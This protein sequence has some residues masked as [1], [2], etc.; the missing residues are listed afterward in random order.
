M[1]VPAVTDVAAT[2]NTAA[3]TATDATR[4]T[5]ATFGP[6]TEAS[7]VPS[8]AF[9]PF[10]D[11]SPEKDQDYFCE[12]LAEELIDALAQL[13]GVRVVARTSS[14]QFKGQNLVEGHAALARMRWCLD[15][16]FPDA[17]RDFRRALELNPA[18]VD[19]RS[20]YAGFLGFMGRT[21]EALEQVAR[22][23]ELDPLSAHASFLGGCALLIGRR[24]E[25][26]IAAFR[27][28]LDLDFDMAGC[29]A[30]L[31]M[32]YQACGQPEEAL[33]TAHKVAA[34]FPI[35][36]GALGHALALA[37]Q[38]SEA[39]RVLAELGEQAKHEY[40]G[41]LVFAY[42][43]LGLGELDAALDQLDQA[44]EERSP[45]LIYLQRPE[46]DSLRDHPRFQ[47]LRRRVGLPDPPASEQSSGS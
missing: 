45:G 29:L 41:P 32:S 20:S 2:L 34:R 33:A 27:Q 40:V 4:P 8:I 1:T 16:Q 44:Y 11:M 43:H 10:A 17:E 37:G 3:P 6:D 22:A 26:A 9:L 47:D 12:G 5:E 35:L 23:Q 46:W 24:Y 25:E 14:F 21:N 13:E 18:N 28:A 19:V 42:T 31:S 7:D 36:R 39:R 38:K 15:W 30:W